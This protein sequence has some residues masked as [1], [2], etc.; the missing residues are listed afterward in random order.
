MN[1]KEIESKS[2][3]QANRKQVCSTDETLISTRTVKI[4]KRYIPKSKKEERRKKHYVG[5][6]PKA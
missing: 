6:T 1:R 5:S 2:C 3:M 4:I